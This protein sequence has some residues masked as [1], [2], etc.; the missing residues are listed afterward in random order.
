MYSLVVIVE[1]FVRA[2]IP[3]SK[4]CSSKI[5]HNKTVINYIFFT[6]ILLINLSSFIFTS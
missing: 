2:A 4:Y 5:L 3:I 1:V 6:K